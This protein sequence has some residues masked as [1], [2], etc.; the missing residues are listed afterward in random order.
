MKNKVN[1][2]NELMDIL[3]SQEADIKICDFV[4]T[5]IF[6]SDNCE[7]IKSCKHCMATFR[8]WLEEEYMEYIEFTEEELVILKNID[9]DYK[10]ISRADNGNLEV[11]DTLSDDCSFWESFRMYNHIFR[12][13]KPGQTIKIKDY[14]PF[15]EAQN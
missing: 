2:L 12:G 10:Y 9:K 4:Q 13:I 11:T 7:C 15:K 8:K 6:H 1:Y 14:L 3:A 5:H